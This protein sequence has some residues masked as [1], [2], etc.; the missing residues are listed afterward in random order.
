MLQKF[1]GVFL[2]SY[3]LII[4]S[5]AASTRE[6]GFDIGTLKTQSTT[7]ANPSSG[8]N[9]IYVK[10][11]NLKLLDSTGSEKSIGSAESD[12]FISDPG[13]ELVNTSCVTYADAAAILPVDGIGGVPNVTATNSTSSPLSGLRSLVFN[14]A[15]SNSQGQ[16][17]S[18]DF[19]IDNASKGKV[20]R[21][22]FDYEIASG[23]YTS[24]DIKVW[25][26]DITNSRLIEPSSYSIESSG[27]K[28]TKFSEWQSSIDSTSYRLIYHITSTSANAYTLKFDSFKIGRGPK[29]YGSV[30]TDPVAFSPTFSGGASYTNEGSFCY[31]E[32]KYLVCD[33]TG[34]IITPNA[35]AFTVQLPYGLKI[36]SSVSPTTTDTFSIQGHLYSVNGTATGIYPT[37][38]AGP[39]Q[40]FVNVADNDSLIYFSR[41][42]SS[43]RFLKAPANDLFVSGSRFRF[44]FKAP[45]KGWSSSQQL[46]QDADTRVV[47]FVGYIGSN[48]SITANVTPITLTALK[49]THGCYSGNSC[50]IPVNGDYFIGSTISTSVANTYNLFVFVNGVSRAVALRAS[51]SLTG[52]GSIVLND[53]KAGDLITLVPDTSMTVS[54]NVNYL[55]Y[56]TR[57]S[58]PSQISASESVSASYWL[59]GNFTSSTTIPINFDSK[60]YDSHNSVTTSPTAWKFTA[61]TAGV[62]TV[63]FSGGTTGSVLIGLF[64]NGTGYKYTP[65]QLTSHSAIYRVKLL[66][67][68]YIDLRASSSTT[69]LGGTLVSQGVCRVSIEKTGNY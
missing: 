60:E 55:T 62:Y 46:S 15:A 21:T 50:R 36:D 23:T 38:G 30:S 3:S 35:T 29:I 49:D 57:I 64:K 5:F 4:S 52:N 61:Q 2:L 31:R 53:L 63:E 54:S 17:F 12:N 67:G 44:L 69:A 18:C 51:N 42:V 33:G 34:T 59:S 13:A 8:K 20:L 58:G 22:Q 65:N 43:S 39:W 25:I 11:G 10:D 26:Y 27:L 37:A 19:T 56:I 40:P 41:S 6:I 47:N 14:K 66:A 7:P 16:G 1:L 48:Q 28:E 68:E 24:G 9:K 45:I 32:G